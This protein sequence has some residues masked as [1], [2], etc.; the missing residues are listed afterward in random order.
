MA[1]RKREREENEVDTAVTELEAAL[2]RDSDIKLKALYAI[3]VLVD[4]HDEMYTV[5]RKAAE[6]GALPMLMQL[7]E[8]DSEVVRVEAAKALT[9]LAKHSTSAM[10][11]LDVGRTTG[12]S[13]TPEKVALNPVQESVT[14]LDGVFSVLT[15]MRFSDG[16]DIQAAGTAALT[17][18]CALNRANTLALLRELV[19][20]LLQH[21]PK[22]LLAL[23]DML[24]GLDVRDDM[25]VLLDQAISP[26]LTL[27]R[28][29]EA[30]DEKLDAVTLLGSICEKRPGAA[31]FLVAEGALPAVTQLLVE[32]DLA[33]TDAAARTLWLLV[34]DNR[35]LLNPDKDALGVAG[36][37]LVEPL[38]TLVETREDQESAQESEQADDE[39]D[40]DGDK[41]G[42]AGTTGDGNI[43]VDNG[44]DALLLLRAL[45][46]QDP[47]VKDKLKGQSEILGTRCSIM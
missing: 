2:G 35:K 17:A 5:Q 41:P 14:E 12:F 15:N 23:E 20:R 43:A 39:Q 21:E 1:D 38:L 45:A 6:A 9:L 8:D 36:S 7:L 44:D 19:H 22:A 42:Q 34:K 37:K 24:A 26:A 13:Q 16:P 47:E 40:A 29:G 27:L 25:A 10:Q 28:S 30:N 4:V 11:R 31:A 18:I 33:I 3:K 32:G 46:A